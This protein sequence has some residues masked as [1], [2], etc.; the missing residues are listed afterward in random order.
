MRRP[1]RDP[2]LS[3]PWRTTSCEAPGSLIEAKLSLK[4]LSKGLVRDVAG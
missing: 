3:Q 4:F 1:L 2:Y